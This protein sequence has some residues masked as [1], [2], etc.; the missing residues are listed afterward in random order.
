MVSISS[1]QPIPSESLF[2]PASSYALH[3][4]ARYDFGSHFKLGYEYF[5]GSKNWYG[6]SRVSANDPLNIR[7]TRGDVHDVYAIFQ[8]DQF[9]FFRLSYTH[10]KRNYQT[11]SSPSAPIATDITTQNLSLAYILRF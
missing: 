10:L 9:Q 6:F 2:D 5:H 7:N 8:L 11:P 1:N 3:V 4:G